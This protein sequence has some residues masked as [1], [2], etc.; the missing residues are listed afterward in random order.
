MM[1][2]FFFLVFFPIGKLGL[3]YLEKD[4]FYQKK[5][6]KVDNILVL[7]GPENASRTEISNKLN[8]GDG[9]ERLIASIKLA[10]EF[11]NSKIVFL[12]GDGKLIKKN[13]MKYQLLNYFIKM[14]VL[15]LIELFLLIIQEILWKT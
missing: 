2:L 9:S 7:A 11:K 6:N 1:I 4:F 13:L 3:T 14:L 12:G 5:L 15:I 8:I 10:R